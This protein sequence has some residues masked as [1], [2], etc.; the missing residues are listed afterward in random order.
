MAVML[1]RALKQLGKESAGVTPWL[2]FGWAAFASRPTN[3]NCGPEGLW[4]LPGPDSTTSECRL[5]NTVRDGRLVTGHGLA[6]S[7]RFAVRRGSS[8]FCC[9]LA[10]IQVAMTVTCWPHGIVQ[11]GGSMVRHPVYSSTGCTADAG[12]PAAGSG[13][14]PCGFQRLAPGCR[15]VAWAHSLHPF[16]C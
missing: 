13:N 1:E 9:E 3:P 5:E 8:T 16:Y 7:H 4:C 2:A 6:S 15:Q 10:G 12:A 14:A 11:A